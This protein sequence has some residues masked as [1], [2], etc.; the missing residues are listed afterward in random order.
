MWHQYRI[1][2][3]PHYGQLSGIRDKFGNESNSVGVPALRR[4][5]NPRGIIKIGG[6]S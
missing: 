2:L 5:G 1:E 6:P 4:N 3:Y